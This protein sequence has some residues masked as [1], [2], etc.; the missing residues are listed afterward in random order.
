MECTGWRRAR[1]QVIDVFLR[2]RP[3][4]AEGNPAVS[5]G[6]DSIYKCEHNAAALVTAG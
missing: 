6:D 2:Q 4:T 3:E 5:D 1:K